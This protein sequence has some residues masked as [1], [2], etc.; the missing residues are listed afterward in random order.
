MEKAIVSYR[1]ALQY[2]PNFYDGKQSS[3]PL[4]KGK[5]ILSQSDYD[6]LFLYTL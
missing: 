6:V 5:M 3:C 4:L 2:D 1:K